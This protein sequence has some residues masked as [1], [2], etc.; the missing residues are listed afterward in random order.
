M[1]AKPIKTVGELIEAL[2][3]Y[4]PDAYV[5]GTWEGLLKP[6]RVYLARNDVVIIDADGGDYQTYF[7]QLVCADCG[8]PADGFYKDSPYCYGCWAT[9]EDG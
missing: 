3:L 9:R 6:I 1:E 4:D 7:Q 2:R 8:C 5:E